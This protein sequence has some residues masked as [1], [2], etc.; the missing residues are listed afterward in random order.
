MKR[1]SYKILF[2]ASALLCLSQFCFAQADKLV[3]KWAGKLQSPQGERETAATFTKEGD[4]V[5]GTMQGMRPGSENK[6]TDLKVEGNKVTAKANVETPNGALTI[7]YSFTLDGDNL[8]GQ[9]ALDFNGQPFTFDI[10]LKRVGATATAT[11]AGGASTTPPGGAARVARTN[12]PQPV[13]KQSIDYFVG[14]W[15]YRYL[16]RESTLGAAPRDCTVTFTKQADGKSVAGV[17]EC[18]ADGSV[19]KSTSLLVFDEATK[20]VTLTE[21]LPGGITISSKGDWTSPIAIKFAVDPIKTKQEALQLKRTYSIVSGHSFS[22]AEELSED[23]GP[24]VR[25]GNA[26]VSKAYAQ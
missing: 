1:A 25:L 16:G 6:L 7:N 26:V 12:V 10:Q 9:G 20:L 18:K 24:F 23:G 22:I 19:I 4:A 14:T 2:V 5:I 11:N 8:N 13:Q 3:G 21:T 17:T 15:S